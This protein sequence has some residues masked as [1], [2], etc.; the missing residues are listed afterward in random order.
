MG[1]DIEKKGRRLSKSLSI[2]VRGFFPNLYLSELKIIMILETLV[3]IKLDSQQ[4][5]FQRFFSGIDIVKI[6]PLSNNI[7]EVNVNNTKVY[8]KIFTLEDF[9]VCVTLESK[10]F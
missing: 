5:N 3:K 6:S 2:K 9:N 4:F 7:Y 10:K 8:S 1:L